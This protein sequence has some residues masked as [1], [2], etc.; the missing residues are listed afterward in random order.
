MKST[1][2]WNAPNIGA[3]NSSG[4]AG[5]PGGA[6]HTDGSFKDVVFGTIWWSAVDLDTN[7]AW[8]RFVYSASADLLRAVHNKIYGFSVRVVRD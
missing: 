1:T 5:L 7:G 4:F 2:G 8:Y 3:T 6:R